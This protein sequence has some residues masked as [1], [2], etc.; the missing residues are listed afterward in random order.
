MHYRGVMKLAAYLKS[1]SIA[2]S[3]YAER[4][5][6]SASTVTRPCSGT[7]IPGLQ[8]IVAA[9]IDSKGEVGLDDWI[10]QFRPILIERGMIPEKDFESW[11]QENQPK[12][13]TAT[14]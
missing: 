7:A 3:V 13:A 2:P 8:L 4:L 6:V 14:A 11:L 5:G 9:Y 12:P 10:E 1:R